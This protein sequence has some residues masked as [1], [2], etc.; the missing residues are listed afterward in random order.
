LNSRLFV[1]PRVCKPPTFSPFNLI[2]HLQAERPAL[3]PFYFSPLFPLHPKAKVTLACTN[4]P[5]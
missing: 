2:P 1:D 5:F 4:S 3:R